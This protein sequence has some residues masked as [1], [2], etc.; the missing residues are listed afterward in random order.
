MFAES[1][2]IRKWFEQL[3]LSRSSEQW[4]FFH[5][6]VEH[7]EKKLAFNGRV[8]SSIHESFNLLPTAHT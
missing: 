7:V 5:A 6:Y 2:E 1:D 4:N 3:F 8:F